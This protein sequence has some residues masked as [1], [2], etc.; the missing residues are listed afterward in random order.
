MNITQDYEM[1]SIIS[2]S[3]LIEKISNAC[4]IPLDCNQFVDS[5]LL[6]RLVDA[7]A[8][9]RVESVERLASHSDSDRNCMLY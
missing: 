3:S 2:S 8:K 6:V 5:F 7:C 9:D 1:F 4:F